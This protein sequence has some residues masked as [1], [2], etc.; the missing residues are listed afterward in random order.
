[1]GCSYPKQVDRIFWGLK[2][3]LILIDNTFLQNYDSSHELI[4]AVVLT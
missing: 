3:E 4:I 2:G 1:M